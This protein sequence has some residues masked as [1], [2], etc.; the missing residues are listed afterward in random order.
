MGKAQTVSIMA[1]IVILLSEEGED[2]WYWWEAGQ[3]KQRKCHGVGSWVAPVVELTHAPSRVVIIVP[4]HI[5][6]FDPAGKVSFQKYS[7]VAI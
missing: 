6:L 5:K 3:C 7:I 4:F 1:E 2:D